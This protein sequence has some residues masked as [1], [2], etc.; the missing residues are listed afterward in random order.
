MKWELSYD[1]LDEMVYKKYDKVNSLL[2]TLYLILSSFYAYFRCDIE[3]DM[4]FI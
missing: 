2:K 3:N 1:I 4:K